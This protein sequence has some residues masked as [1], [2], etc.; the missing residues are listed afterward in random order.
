MPE[1]TSEFTTTTPNSLTERGPTTGTPADTSHA[2]ARPKKKTI[3][4]LPSQ[5]QPGAEPKCKRHFYHVPLKMSTIHD[6]PKW[7]EKLSKTSSPIRPKNP[8]EVE[9]AFSKTL[10]SLPLQKHI[11]EL[12]SRFTTE[13]YLAAV[14]QW[15]HK[16]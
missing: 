15:S 14:F 9:T 2:G 16:L 7:T 8:N 4:T 1:Q 6:L 13:D 5:Q 10:D 12:C 3:T 11:H